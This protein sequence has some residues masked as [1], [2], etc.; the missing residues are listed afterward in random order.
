MVPFI[1]ASSWTVFLNYSALQ[2][3][4]PFSNEIFSVATIVLAVV[5]LCINPLTDLAVSEFS[6]KLLLFFSFYV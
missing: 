1:R 6:G 3:Y 5:G 4:A 2:P